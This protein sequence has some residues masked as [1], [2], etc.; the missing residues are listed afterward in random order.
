MIINFCFCPLVPYFLIL[1]SF[2]PV[3]SH[4]VKYS[5]DVAFTCSSII[6]HLETLKTEAGE[7]ARKVEETDVV[8]AEVETVSQQYI[9]LA[10][11]CSSIY[12]TL[13]ALNQVSPPSMN[14]SLHLVF[15]QYELQP[16]SSCLSG[17]I[18]QI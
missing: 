16:S 13:E 14:Y 4:V 18:S 7:I 5:I 8:M 6:S 3:P 17:H 10:Q 12:F 1:F 15:I 2:S 9:P 11:S